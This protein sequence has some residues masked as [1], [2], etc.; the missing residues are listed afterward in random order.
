MWNEIFDGIGRKLLL[1][2]AELISA[3]NLSII[4]WSLSKHMEQNHMFRI[5]YCAQQQI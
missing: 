2:K 4:H 3:L 5:E 1:T